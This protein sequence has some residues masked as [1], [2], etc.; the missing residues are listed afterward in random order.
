[1]AN[2]THTVRTITEHRFTVP[3]ELPHGETGRTSM[4]HARWPRTSHVSTASTPA[5]T[6]G[7]GCAAKMIS[8]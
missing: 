8:W 4:S 7:L 5:P 6:V 3:C 2:A 1:M